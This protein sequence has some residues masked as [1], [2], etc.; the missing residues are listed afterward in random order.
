MSTTAPPLP[1][2]WVQ[3][4]RWSAAVFAAKVWGL[5]ARRAAA[6]VLPSSPL[7][8]TPEAIE[9]TSLFA[10]HRSSLMGDVDPAER[11]FQLGKVV[12]LRRA[13]EGLDNIVIPKGSVF[14]FWRQVGPPTQ[15][16]GFAVGRM[17]QQGCLVP[18]VGGGL[19]QLSNALFEAAV[20]SGCEIVERH[21]HSRTV[22]GSAAEAG[23]DATVA[24]NYVDLRLKPPITLRLQVKLEDGDLVVRFLGPAGAARA[25][26]TVITAP[27]L[28]PI[29]ARSCGTCNET[30]CFRHEKREKADA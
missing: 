13:A 29:T 25:E 8:H 7:R 11:D 20:Q 27:T 18:S 10:E 15:A 22:P 17:L 16:R 12:N 5:R 30:A 28:P 6:D 3:P 9:L 21:A 4:T 2:E 26:P 1:A 19:C 23:R 24:W 14:S